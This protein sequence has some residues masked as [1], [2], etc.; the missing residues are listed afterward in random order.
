MSRW[1]VRWTPSAALSEAFAFIRRLTLFLLGVGVTLDAIVG[2]NPT[3]LAELIAGLVLLGL[4]PVEMLVD[5]ITVR[6]RPKAASRHGGNGGNADETTR[7]D[8]A[9][10]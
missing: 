1:T 9:A 6:V 2:K 3:P 5:R 8:Q 10:P 4:V 7:T